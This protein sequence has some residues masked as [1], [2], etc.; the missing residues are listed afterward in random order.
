MDICLKE[1]LPG[2]NVKIISDKGELIDLE[3]NP[4][5][6]KSLLSI[7]WYRPPTS[8]MDEVSFEYPRDILKKAVRR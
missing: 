3:F 2:S 8:G 6:A 4:I 7:S 5:H 1:S